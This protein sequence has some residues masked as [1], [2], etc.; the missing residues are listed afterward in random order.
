M[1]DF[2]LKKELLISYI[3][4]LTK[5]DIKKYIAKQSISYNDN[6][7]D[8]IYNAIKNNYNEILNS[9]FMN[10]ISKYQS[11]INSELYNAI[12]EKYNQY[13]KFIE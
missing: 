13:K 9:N 6:E 4:N 7:I 12:I 2:I 3:S 1:G 11:S 10:Y 8:I 5:E